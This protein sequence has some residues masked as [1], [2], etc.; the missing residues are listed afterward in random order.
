MHTFQSV[1]F[2]L[3]GTLTD[4]GVGITKSVAYAL[5]TFGIS[6]PPLQSLYPFI[7]PPLADS[8]MKYYKMDRD[9]ALAAV[10]KYRE[11]F[12]VLGLFENQVYPGIYDMLRS[13][14]YAGL[15][16]YIATSKPEEFTEQILSHFGLRRF[17]DFVSGSTMDSSRVKKG[18]VIHHLFQCVPA[19]YTER[20]IMVGDRCHDMIGARENGIPAIGVLWGYGSKRELTDSGAGMLA[21]TP[22]DLLQK[23]LQ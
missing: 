22:S 5:Q 2:D 10:E 11:Y 20:C 19:L 15:R 17:F 7:G 1:F 13:L 18:D 12:S 14:K 9:T 6:P 23:L 21:A 4:P 8:F 3:D 16:L